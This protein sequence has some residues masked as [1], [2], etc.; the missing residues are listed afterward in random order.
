MRIKKDFVLRKVADVYVVVPVNSLTLDFNGIINLN[1]TGAFLFKLLQSGADKQELVNKLLEEYGVT[2]E[3]LHMDAI[4]AQLVSHP[5]VLKNMSEMMAEMSGGMFDMP[6][7][8]MW[9]ATVEGGMNG[10]SVTQ[11]PDFLQEAA[12]RLGGDYFVLPSSVHE[13]L[14]IRDDGSFERDQL[15]SMVRGVNATEVSEADFLAEIDRINKDESVHGILMM[16]PLPT[17]G[18]NLAFLK[19]WCD[20]RDKW[21]SNEFELDSTSYLIGDS[22]GN[23]VVDIND[24]TTVQRLLANKIKDKNG[25]ITLR[26]SVTGEPLGISDATSV[27]KYL[28]FIPTSCPSYT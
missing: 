9:V 25:T 8:P 23:G 18:E 7:S 20:E 14:F 5:P 10:A 26:G 13:V 17:Y 28:A 6:E 22:D 16:Q 11:L 21:L 12:D 2:P 3:Q 24:V 19:N 1:E 15:E 27:Q 4:A